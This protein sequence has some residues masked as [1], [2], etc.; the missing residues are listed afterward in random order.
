M[1]QWLWDETSQSYHC[2]FNVS[3]VKEQRMY[4]TDPEYPILIKDEPTAEPTTEE[5]NNDKLS[6]CLAPDTTK[7]TALHPNCNPLYEHGVYRDD[8]DGWM[9]NS[10]GSR[11]LWVR[12]DTSTTEI[13]FAIKVHKHLDV[14]RQ[15]GPKIEHRGIRVQAQD[16]NIMQLARSS[17]GGEGRQ[18][19]PAVYA[20]CGQH[21]AMQY[22]DR[23][24]L[25]DYVRGRRYSAAQAERK[26]SPLDLLRVSLQ[27]FGSLGILH[28][29]GV[30][31]NDLG[32]D[33]ILQFEGVYQVNDYDH[34]IVRRQRRQQYVAGNETN[35]PAMSY[36]PDGLFMKIYKDSA[37]EQ[38]RVRGSREGWYQWPND[39]SQEDRALLDTFK[40]DVYL[41]GNVLYLLL[42]NRYPFEEKS[43]L[44]AVTL[45]SNGHRPSLVVANDDHNTTQSIEDALKDDAHSFDISGYNSTD[46]AI[47]AVIQAIHLA[48]TD[49]PE[50]RPGAKAIKEYLGNELAKLDNEYQRTR[51]I[52]PVTT[53]QHEHQVSKYDWQTHNEE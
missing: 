24:T 50:Q 45:I 19:F 4:E 14:D 23:G 46:L 43:F 48:W 10:G 17:L 52:H 6:E 3:F 20:Y 2:S 44:E 5:E 16:A 33:Q 36:C 40:V 12:R 35:G 51:Q 25:Y 8:A 31:H 11:R 30:A 37:A 39:S 42:T 22:T 34:A 49:D 21:V 29:L 28:D 26:F 18:L 41:A 15:N 13:P 32:T 9:V 27:V 53:P 38:M 47:Q 1:V 7:W